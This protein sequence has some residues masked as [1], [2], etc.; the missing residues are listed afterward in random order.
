MVPIIPSLLRVRVRW[1]V[2][3]VGN[4]MRSRMEGVLHRSI[5]MCVRE[6]RNRLD[7]LKIVQ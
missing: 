2:L 1:D 3:G 6:M 7:A 5:N 4:A